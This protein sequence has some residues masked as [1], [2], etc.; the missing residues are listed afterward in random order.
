MAPRKLQ[1]VRK[2][3]FDDVIRIQTTRKDNMKAETARGCNENSKLDKFEKVELFEEARARSEPVEIKVFERGK[4][5]SIS[6][7]PDLLS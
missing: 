3:T 2:A 4:P 7:R 5:T 6:T 1:R